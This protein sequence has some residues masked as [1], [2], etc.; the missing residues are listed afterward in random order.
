MME[1]IKVFTFDI[2]SSR[3]KKKMVEEEVILHEK[4]PIGLDVTNEVA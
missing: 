4:S 1:I 3:G 2:I